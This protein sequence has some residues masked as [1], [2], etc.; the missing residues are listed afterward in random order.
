MARVRRQFAHLQVT[1]K[2]ATCETEPFDLREF[3]CL[4]VYMP[5]AWTAASLGMKVSP[6]LNTTFKTLYATDV[7][8]TTAV[9][10][11]CASVQANGAYTFPEA[12]K[13]SAYVR[14]WSHKSGV[15]ENQGAE[16]VV[17]VSLKG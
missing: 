17:G 1:F 12:A 3:E 5:S 2:N 7:C 16:R 11:Q 10:V 9:Y 14:L 13:C 6:V 8:C 4:Q 15:D